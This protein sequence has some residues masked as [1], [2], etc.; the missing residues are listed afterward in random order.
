MEKEQIEKE[1][2]SWWWNLGTFGIYDRLQEIM[3]HGRYGE[4]VSP[5]DVG[6][7]LSYA[8]DESKMEGAF[9]DMATALDEK[10]LCSGVEDAFSTAQ[11]A[12][13][14]NVGAR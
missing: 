9:K 10:C 5:E 6:Q 8:Y 2:N 4:S 12:E 14:V 3:I 11:E 13:L 1:V 7:M